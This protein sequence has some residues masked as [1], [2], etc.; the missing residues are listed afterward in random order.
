[1]SGVA[2]RIEEA[3]DA[4]RRVFGFA[5]F[6]GVQSRVVVARIN[7]LCGFEPV[8][9]DMRGALERRGEHVLRHAR[10]R[11]KVEFG[12]CYVGHGIS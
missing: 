8:L 1:M 5:A 2:E 4:L 11:G 3:Q 6:R 10:Q 12:F 9:A 7:A